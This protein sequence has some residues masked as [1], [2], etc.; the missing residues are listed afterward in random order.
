MDTVKIF[1][2][3]VKNDSFWNRIIRGLGNKG[4][5]TAR[6]YEDVDVSIVLSGKAENPVGFRGRKVL[7]YKKQEWV[8][9]IPVPLGFN[10][11][12]PILKEYY[13]EMHD[14]SALNENECVYEII[15][16][17]GGLNV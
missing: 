10:M 14:I 7:F 16:Y 12:K 2:S 15:G 1:K 6:K 9:H 4:Y 3:P 17:I 11:F 5:E 13:D 8:P